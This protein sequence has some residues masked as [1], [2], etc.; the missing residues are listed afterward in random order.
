MIHKGYLV[1]YTHHLKKEPSSPGDSGTQI[2]ID[3]HPL[4]WAS[5][6]PAIFGKYEWT[7]IQSWQEFEADDTLIRIV[8]AG[9]VFD[10]ETLAGN[11]TSALAS[12]EDADH[13]ETL[14]GRDF[15]RYRAL[16]GYKNSITPDRWRGQVRDKEQI[17]SSSEVDENG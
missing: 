13:D 1:H 16:L 14:R 8:R 10:I 17:T 12:S 2:L 6:P 5:W 7:S 3:I 11:I 15:L 9:G 4:V